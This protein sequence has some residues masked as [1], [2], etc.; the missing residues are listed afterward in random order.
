MLDNKKHGFGIFYLSN[1]K[2]LIGFWKD[3]KQNGFVKNINEDR[4]DYGI[5]KDGKKEKIFEN[6]NE[7]WINFI[8]KESK[9]YKA[10]F[11]MDKINVYSLINSEESDL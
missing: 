11:K 4:I 5:Y 10:F 3:G 7:F 9:K 6:E 8:D 1:D 2:Y